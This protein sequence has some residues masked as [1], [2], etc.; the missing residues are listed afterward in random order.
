MLIEIS[1][2]VRMKIPEL[3]T[4]KDIVRTDFISLLM[5]AILHDRNEAK[6]EMRLSSLVIV[7]NG[8]HNVFRSITI[9]QKIICN[10]EKVI[11]SFWPQILRCR[12]NPAC[13]YFYIIP[14]VTIQFRL[15]M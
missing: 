11:V 15:A 7:N 4:V 2:Q 5:L 6:M 10:C 14:A 3:S 13:H 9:F 1:L 12:H 8:L